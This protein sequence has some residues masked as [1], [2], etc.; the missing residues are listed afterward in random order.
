MSI[1]KTTSEMKKIWLM[2]L[3]LLLPYSK[4]CAQDDVQNLEKAHE[5]LDL[6][7]NCAEAS[8]YLNL[9]S[10]AARQGAPYLLN[11]AKSQDCM[12]NT[13]QA[14]YYYNKYLT[15][16]PGN[17]SVMR[18]VAELTD[19]KNKGEKNNER[20]I[21][22]NK[23][24]SKKHKKKG[25]NLVDNYYYSGLGYGMGLGANAPLRSGVSFV[26][27]D[28][29]VIMQ[30]RAVLEINVTASLMESPNREWDASTTLLLPPGAS[31]IAVDAGSA[32]SFSIGFSPVLVNNRN[33][34]V[35]AG[36][37]GGINL[38]S[39]WGNIASDIDIPTNISAC[40]GINANLY[41]GDHVMF[42]GRLLLTAAN[43]LK[44]DTYGGEY[45]VPASYSAANLGICVKLDSWWW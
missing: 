3:L 1:E 6:S 15:Q 23:P 34:A 39:F 2:P 7:H 42:F 25:K 27:G 26:A 4:A 33:I 24:A 20:N 14:I 35:A 43:S 36:V 44:I 5:A 28:G 18:R 29:F 9:V 38:Y 10:P 30:N 13:A 32:E 16:Q 31:A 8:K 19:Q 12:N 40:Y 11:M 45:T 41:L 21:N 37:F 17:D 22:T